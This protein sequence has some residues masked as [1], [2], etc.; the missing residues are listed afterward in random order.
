VQALHDAD[1]TILVCEGELDAVAAT[2]AGWPAVGVPGAQGWKD[3][4]ARLL[5]DFERVVVVSDGDD[6]GA[7][8]GKT[9][10]ERIEHAEVRLMPD[11]HDVNSFLLEEGAEAFGDWIAP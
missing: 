2:Y 4:W 11:G 7:L 6:A 5:D 10:R 1:S 3:H 9:I 8:M